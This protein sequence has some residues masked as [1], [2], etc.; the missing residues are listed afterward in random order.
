MSRFYLDS[1]RPRKK[2]GGININPANRDK[3]T[4]TMKRTGKSAE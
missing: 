3:F 4:V 1:I 2:Y